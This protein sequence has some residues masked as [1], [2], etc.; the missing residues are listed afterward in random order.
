MPTAL[1]LRGVSA[2]YGP[3]RALFDVSIEVGP[4]E[5]VALLGAN[6]AGKTTVARVATGLLPPTAGTVEVGGG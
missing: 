3:F 4:G 2:A 5:A 1:A 6:G